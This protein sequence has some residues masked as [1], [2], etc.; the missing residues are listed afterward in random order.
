MDTKEEMWRVTGNYQMF[1]MMNAMLAIMAV[2]FYCMFVLDTP[3]NSYLGGITIHAFIQITIITHISVAIFL[4]KKAISVGVAKNEL[5]M[6]ALG[7]A[8][9]IMLS[10][11]APALLAPSEFLDE[12][13]SLFGS[14]EISIDECVVLFHAGNTEDQIVAYIDG[15]TLLADEFNVDLSKKY[16][17]IPLV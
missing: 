5:F 10:L 17:D 9:V 14:N 12:C 16:R 11:V 6:P 15:K 1:F 3:V 4:S 8:M 13:I 2:V 7:I